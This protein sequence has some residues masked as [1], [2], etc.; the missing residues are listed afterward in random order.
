MSLKVGP[1]IYERLHHRGDWRQWSVCKAGE[2]LPGRGTGKG[3]HSNAVLSERGW[4]L[5]GY[6]NWSG[7]VYAAHVHAIVI[8]RA[9]QPVEPA[10]RSRYGAWAKLVIS[11][12]IVGVVWAFIDLRD[13]GQRLLRLEPGWVLVAIGVSL[14]Q[15]V[16]LGLRWSFIADALD[17]P[18]GKSRAIVEYALSRPLNQL[19]PSGVA[20]DAMRGLRH[21]RFVERKRRLRV[22]E[23]L[24]L[25]RLSGQLG[26]WVLVLLTSR[27]S[28]G[29]TWPFSSY[30]LG[31]FGLVG[32]VLAIWLVVQL[33]RYPAGGSTR[34]SRLR[35]L[36]RR[37]GVAL[38]RPPGVFV[39]LTFS[40][41]LVL[42]LVLQ[43]AVAARALGL[44]FAAT[45][46]LWLG[47]L[48]F[49]AASLPSL[50]GGFGAREG[51]AA[52]LVTALGLPAS[53]GLS[54]SVTF[55]LL[56]LL[57]VLPGLLVLVFDRWTL[58]RRKAAG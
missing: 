14:L 49:L 3:V 10:A 21:A 33:P 37:N 44:S 19:L 52:L 36:I 5:Y 57:G 40:V 9:S 29:A 42:S 53:A 54:L 55:G 47:P 45:E 51:A 22:A 38:L 25:D 20:G 28:V 6:S 43:L 1:T 15:S 46:L 13:V 39:H 23:A 8:K 11:L 18:L 58:E 34:L 30:H 56:D 31:V 26:L 41:L 12:A 16:L 24:A 17:V 7:A 50:V 2:E 48:M 32:G 35:D 4:R 27:L